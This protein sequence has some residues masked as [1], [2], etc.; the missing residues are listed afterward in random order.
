MWAFAA[1]TTLSFI[2]DVYHGVWASSWNDALDLMKKSFNDPDKAG[3]RY[4]QRFLFYYGAMWTLAFRAIG[5]AAGAVPPGE[6]GVIGWT[7]G[8]INAKYLAVL[9]VTGKVQSFFGGRAYAG[10]NHAVDT[11]A[12]PRQVRDFIQQWGRDLF[13]CL[14]GALLGTGVKITP[15]ITGYSLQVWVSMKSFTELGKVE[16]KDEI[17]FSQLP[18]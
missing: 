14:C 2:L 16:S 17:S 15:G 12:M 9:I 6:L 1:A 18:R 10:L 13:F 4:T 11:G 8:F 5:A 3:L 7:E